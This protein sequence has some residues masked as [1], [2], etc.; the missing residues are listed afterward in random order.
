MDFH[1]L[2]KRRCLKLAQ[3]F[4]GADRRHCFIFTDDPAQ[5]ITNLSAGYTSLEVQI[6]MGRFASSPLRKAMSN[7]WHTPQETLSG[8]VLQDLEVREPEFKIIKLNESHSANFRVG[9]GGTPMARMISALTDREFVHQ[10]LP[11]LGD[12]TFNES[13][14]FVELSGIKE[15][16][17][18]QL[19]C[20]GRRVQSQ[21]QDHGD[22]GSLPLVNWVLPLSCFHRFDAP[23]THIDDRLTLLIDGKA[24]CEFVSNYYRELGLKNG[25]WDDEL[26]SELTRSVCC[27]S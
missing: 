3:P 11:F 17:V 15:E 5:S 19:I 12:S 7:L 10:C 6:E 26:V 4:S 25:V 24:G 18:R 22:A 8:V 2:F 27:P 1:G 14:F 9:Y 20:Q 16:N 23:D 21:I 13:V